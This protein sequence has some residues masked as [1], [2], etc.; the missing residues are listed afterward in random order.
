MWT[1]RTH[2]HVCYKNIFSL[3]FAINVS[4]N[5]QDHDALKGNGVGGERSSYINNI[6]QRASFFS[7]PEYIRFAFRRKVAG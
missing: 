7:I 2:K 4:R 6:Q 1:L 5:L 3:I